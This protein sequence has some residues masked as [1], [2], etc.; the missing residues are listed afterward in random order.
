[1]TV[2]GLTALINDYFDLLA[3]ECEIPDPVQ[4]RITVGAVF[5]DLYALL[6]ADESQMHPA[7]AACLAVTAAAA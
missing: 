3:T 4:A 6:G 5:A 2:D 1:M 7:V